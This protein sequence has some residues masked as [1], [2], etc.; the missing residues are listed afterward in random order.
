M[1]KL[2]N[3]IINYIFE[4]YNP[5][6]EIFNKVIYNI[7]D[8][9]LKIYNKYYSDYTFI[10]TTIYNYKLFTFE[11]ENSKI[12]MIDKDK[13]YELFK[14]MIKENLYLMNNQLLYKYRLD[15]N[16]TIY[17]IKK[18]NTYPLIDYSLKEFV[19]RSTFINNIF[20]NMIDIDS[21]IFNEFIN[22]YSLEE[23]IKQFIFIDYYEM[24]YQCTL[25]EF[26]KTF[27]IFEI[28]YDIL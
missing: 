26:N 16:I 20:Y 10:E 24:N 23:L 13:I 19:N 9:E 12:L 17:N 18:I 28:I 21:L 2:P 4:F 25:K 22:K 5:Y 27:L 15:K 1:N 7:M 14:T 6:K 8:D 3:D 11:K